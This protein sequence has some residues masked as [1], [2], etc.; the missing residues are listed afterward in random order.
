MKKKIEE[1]VIPKRFK[2]MNRRPKKLDVNLDSDD[3]DRPSKKN[4]HRSC[5]RL[6]KKYQTTRSR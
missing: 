3:E 4:I 6:L 5:Q 2:G 1:T